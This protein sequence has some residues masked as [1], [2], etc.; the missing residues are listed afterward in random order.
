MADVHTKAVRS[1]NMSRILAKD[2]KPEMIVRRLVHSLGFRYRLHV[3]KLS[4]CPDLV[5]SKKKK[6]I[7]VHG[8]FWHVHSCKYGKVIPKTNALFWS[9][10]RLGN[11]ERDRRNIA[12]LKKLGW[13][14]L[15][16]WEC[17]S[18]DLSKLK[19]RITTFLNK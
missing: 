18:N 12:E 6:V 14:I 4:G 16:I 1:Y 7:F 8:C 3:K 5:F 11:K 13:K 15:I 2:T 10:K 17:Q 19:D 9:A